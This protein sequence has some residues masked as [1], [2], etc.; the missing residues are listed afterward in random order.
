MLTPQASPEQLQHDEWILRWTREYLAQKNVLTAL[1]ILGPHSVDI[2]VFYDH[3]PAIMFVEVK[4]AHAKPSP[5]ESHVKRIIQSRPK[6]G[7]EIRR[8]QT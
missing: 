2:V 7:Y 3:P 4:G 1:P 8:Y 5:L 6:L